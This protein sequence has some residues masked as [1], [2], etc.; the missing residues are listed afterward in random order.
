MNFE[1]IV[2]IFFL[3]GVR[4][5]TFLSANFHEFS[6]KGYA[7]IRCAICDVRYAICDAFFCGVTKISDSG[8]TKIGDTAGTC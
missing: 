6:R 3:G 1:T 2:L 4:P 5:L 7:I 8:V